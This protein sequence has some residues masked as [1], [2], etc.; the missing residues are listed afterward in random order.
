ML[1]VKRKKYT[2]YGIVR[3]MQL[4]ET[5]KRVYWATAGNAAN[6]GKVTVDLID[7][8]LGGTIKSSRIQRTGFSHSFETKR[9][10]TPP[11]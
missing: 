3:E 6:K 7:E 1:Y 10:K 8:G 11:E 2:I 4:E 5:I 9:Q